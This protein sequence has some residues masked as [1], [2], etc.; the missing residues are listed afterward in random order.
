[1]AF[2]TVALLTGC[3]GRAAAEACSCKAMWSN[4]F[5]SNQEGCPATA[6]DSWYTSWCEVEPAGCDGSDLSNGVYWMNCDQSTPVQSCGSATFVA[7]ASG[8]S[9][10]KSSDLQN[11]YDSV[12]C[13]DLCESDGECGTD[14]NLNNCGSGSGF[15]GKVMTYN[16]L[17]YTSYA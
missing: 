2:T 1:M 16:R 15:V 5:C 10:C 6:C 14:N 12:A 17:G 7:L 3:L 4:T 13:G 11:C 9:D 8:S